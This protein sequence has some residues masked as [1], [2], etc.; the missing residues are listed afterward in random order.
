MRKITI[1]LTAVLS[2]MFSYA[3]VGI[4]ENFNSGTPSGWTDNYSNTGSQSCEGN[5][6]RVNLYGGNFGVLSAN[7]TSP[8]LVG[9]SNATDLT[10]SFEYKVVNWSAATVATPAGWGTAEL[11][12]SN[13]DGATWTTAFTIDDSNHIVD[14]ECAVASTTIA[15]TDLPMDSD[16]KL[17][18]LNTW[19]GGDYFFYVDN[20]IASQVAENPPN[21]DAVLAEETDVEID[22]NIS[23]SAATGVPTFYELTVGTT[24][25][26]SEVLATTNVG[27]VTSYD[28]GTLAFETIYYVTITPYNDNGSATGCT[29]QTFTTIDTPITGSVCSDP[30]V[31]SELP[32]TTSDNT[33]LYGDDYENNSSS[34]SAFYMSGDDVVYAFTPASDG[35]FVFTLSNIGS[36]YSGLHVLDGCVD[37]EPTCVGFVGNSGTED[38]VVEAALT[39]GIT[40]YIVIS[41]WATP[42][43]TAYTLDIEEGCNAAAGTLTAD[44]ASVVLSGTTVTI[45]A[46]E[47]AAPTVPADYDVTYVLTSGADLVIE[48]VSA[49]PSFDVT[50]LGDYTIHTLVALTDSAFETDPNFL[51]LSVVTFGT[52]TAAEVLDIVSENDICAAL[53]AVGAPVNVNDGSVLDFY[54][55]Q[56]VQETGSDPENGSSESLTVEVGTSVTVYAKA[57]EDG[58]TNPEGQGAGIECWIAINDENTDPATWDTTLWQEATYLG[59]NGNDDEY[60]YE[61]ATAPIGSNYVAARWRLDNSGFTYGGFNGAWDGTDNVNIELIVEPLAN[62]DCS[63]AIALTVNP[64]YSCNE[65]TNATIAGA[66]DSGVGNSTCFGTEDDDIWFTFEATSE[67]HRLSLT[68]FTSGTSDMYI[69]FYEGTCGDLGESIECSDPQTVNLE[70]LTPGNTY[71]VQV[72]TWTSNPGQTSTF[73]VCVGTPPTC[74]VPDGLAASFVAPD[75]AD[76]SWEAP[77]DG[78]TPIEYNWEIVPQGNDQGVGVIDSGSTADIFA[79][80]TGLTLDTLY[81]LRVQSNCDGGDLSAWSAVFT[82]NAGYCVPPSTSSATYIDSFSTLGEYENISNLSSGFAPNGFQNN[83]ESLAVSGASNDELDFEIVIVGGTVGSAVWIDWNNDYTFDTSEVA[84]TTTSYGSGPFTGTITIPDGTPN[85]DYRMRVMIDYNDSNPGDDAPCS[86]G[87]GRGETEDY[88]VTVD[89]TLS[90]S[91]I[92]NQ[93]NFTYFPNPINNQLHLKAQSQIDHVVIYNM[94]GQEVLNVSPRALEADLETG[95]FEQG[96]YFAKVTIG[97]TSRTI[98][99]IKE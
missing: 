49:T 24:S 87:N 30:I 72:Y 52:T 45:S 98:K 65:V 11:Q 96:A 75:S 81:D 6:E 51:D 90:T 33:N 56:Y 12:Y 59:D 68:N 97:N 55:V 25:G 69:T 42:Q 20:F 7:L 86:Y 53:D 82:F 73:D 70:G 1:L 4:F 63:G 34:C 5:S 71:Y 79:T 58:L 74:Y 62:D 37:A 23:W 13:D 78:T 18:I 10:V 19:A 84:F 67:E 57:Y 99:L 54:N 31:V 89:S 9:A 61:T 44:E 88:I 85:G 16:V 66:T 32:Y 93:S 77:T 39:S 38:R 21:C 8:N 92:E 94:L 83:T 76:L 35:N 48:Q 14:N 15:G 80:A 29:E 47:D 95:S 91:I 41:T 64:D 3:Q 17:R 27:N 50:E 2:V 26:G 22:G 36:T 40:Y 43:S 60:F 28:L 46:T